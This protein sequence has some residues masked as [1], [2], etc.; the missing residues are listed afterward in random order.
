MLAECGAAHRGNLM[1][2]VLSVFACVATFVAC[3]GDSSHPVEPA[4]SR[5][6]TYT[7]RTVDGNPLPFAYPDAPGYELT[8]ESLTL[9]ADNTFSARTDQRWTEGGQVRTGYVT[10]AG[11]YAINGLELRLLFTTGDLALE[12]FTGDD[13]ITGS[14]CGHSWV[15][16]R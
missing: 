15:Y 3:G 1:R 7:L 4:I 6:G 2:R 12:S 16:R 11:T 13:E 10:G 8:A 5:V 9:N 14:C